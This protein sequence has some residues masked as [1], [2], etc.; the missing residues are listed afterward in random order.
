MLTDEMKERKQDDVVPD[1]SRIRQAGKHLLELIDA[2]L[3][4]S[5]IE[6]GKMEIHLEE[7]AIEPLVREVEAL[8]RPIFEKKGNRLE[9]ALDPDIGFVR[10]D[11]VK[12]RQCLLNLLSNACKF[13]SAGRVSLT[14]SRSGD[15]AGSPQA[16]LPDCP[17]G[18]LRFAVEDSG[19]GMSDEQV[20]KL[21]APFTQADSGTARVYGGTGLGLSITK[22]FAEMMGGSI[23]VTSAPGSGSRFLLSLPA[24]RLP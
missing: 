10:I 5:K 19:I 22:R 4:L 13:T 6:A 15:P 9:V 11:L 2:I 16:V 1:L 18:D 24:S 7:V 20:A 8:V 21:F 14:V 12:T 3:D 23:T 17:G